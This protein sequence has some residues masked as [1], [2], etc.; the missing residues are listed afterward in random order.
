[1]IR[2]KSNRRKPPKREIRLPRIQINWAAVLIPPATA[3]VI[4]ALLLG[5]VRLLDQPVRTLVVEA[6]FERVSAV[7]LEAALAGA[8]GQGFLTIDLRDLR[9]QLQA[10]AWVDRAE[11]SRVWPDTLA[12]RVA[13]Q[14]AAARWGEN[15]LLNVRG[16]LFTNESRHAFPELPQLNGPPGAEREVAGL[17]LTVRGPLTEAGLALASLTLDDRGA[18]ELVLAGGQQIRIGRDD[19]SERLRRF[20]DV[21]APTLAADIDRVMYVDLRYTNGFAVGWAEEVGGDAPAL[22][23]SGES[24][25]RG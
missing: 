3:A 12:V 11:I 8:R 2:A 13:E 4:A 6:S 25:N 24:G 19:V 9:G 14:Q 15:G 17:Y 5:A 21:V 16:D 22:A 23:R 1:M 7:Q 18:W 20:F 10:L